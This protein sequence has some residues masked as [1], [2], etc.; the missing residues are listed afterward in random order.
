LKPNLVSIVHNN[1]ART[2]KKAPYCS[3][4]TINSLTLFEKIIPVYAENHTK[5]TNA[6]C[7]VIGY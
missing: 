1:S 4:A 6:K 7:S 3:I 5:P 2:S